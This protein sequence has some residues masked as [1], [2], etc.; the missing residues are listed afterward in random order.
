ML[1]RLWPT[2][3]WT[4]HRGSDKLAPP[5]PDIVIACGK[6]TAV[7]ALLVRRLTKAAGNH[8]M[9]VYIQQPPVSAARF[10]LVIV[11]R[12]DPLREPNVL[13]T[14][15]ATH[16]ITRD[17]LDAAEADFGALLSNLPRPRV[18]VLIGGSNRRYRL[19]PAIAANLGTSLTTLANREGAGL[20][21]TTSRRTSAE[22]GAVLRASLAGAS[23][24]FWDGAGENPYFGYLALADHILVTCDSVSMASEAAATGKPLHI[25]E[26]DG[27][28]RRIGAFH[29]NLREAGIARPFMGTLDEWGYT[30][31]NDTE[32]VAQVILERWRSDRGD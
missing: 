25:I 27:F 22:A 10:D 8:C 1:P 7:P 14:Q 32:R 16:R 11:P 18:A 19:T 31:P 12:H 26:L 4:L 3:P 28:S 2:T 17:K 29:A 30:P 20:M 23:A 24:H 5:W 15:A 21:I 13:V 9:T 6:R